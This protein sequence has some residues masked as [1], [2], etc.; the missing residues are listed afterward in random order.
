[1]SRWKELRTKELKELN[2][3]IQQTNSRASQVFSEIKLN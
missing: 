1:M 3:Q 2:A